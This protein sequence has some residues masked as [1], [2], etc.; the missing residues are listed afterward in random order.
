MQLGI[1]VVA[2][3]ARIPLPATSWDTGAALAIGMAASAGVLYVT[4]VATGRR[5]NRLIEA[6]TR[7]LQ[8]EAEEHRRTAAE[9][10]ALQRTSSF[11]LQQ[12]PI[13]ITSTDASGVITAV[14]P[15]AVA[16]FGAP[17]AEAMIGLNLPAVPQAVESGVSGVFRRVL[18]GRHSE[19]FET[20]HRSSWGREIELRI[21]VVQLLDGE[22]NL[23]G[24]IAMT[25]DVAERRMATLALADSEQRLAL[26][27]RHMP[28]M[29]FAFDEAYHLLAWNEECERVTGYT[30]AETLGRHDMFNLLFPDDAYRTALL[31]SMTSAQ[32][33]YRDAETEIRCRDGSTR[34]IAWSS[35]SLHAPVPGW[36]AWGVGIDVTARK[37]AEAQLL[38]AQK[39]ESV[40]RLAG[41]VAHDVNNLM[42]A[43]IGHAELAS[44][45]L[46]EIGSLRDDLAEICATAERAGEMAKQLLAFSR[47]QVVEPAEVL[48]D[49]LT[50]SM[51]VMLSRLIGEDVQLVMSAQP[52]LWHVRVDPSQMQQVVLN[53]VVNARDAMP[54]GGMI[55]VRTDNVS[56][57]GREFVRMTVSDTGAG[58]D[59][60]TQQRIFEPFFTTKGAG[61]GSGLGLSTCYGIVSQ[62]GG[63]LEVDS[64]PGQGTTFRIELPR[65]EAPAVE[66]E[67]PRGD[68]AAAAGDAT[69]LLVE[70][71][72]AVRS[73]A[74]RALAAQGYAVLEARNGVEALAVACRHAGHIDLV[75]SDV[76]MPEMGGVE[77]AARLHDS[78]PATRIMY[79]SG[80]T[81]DQTIPIPPSG[82]PVPVLTKPF[83]SAILVRRVREVLRSQAAP[84]TAA[85]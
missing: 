35:L 64:A 43:I 12:A 75:L 29:I 57:D 3:I 67:A 41:G 74:V 39:M 2:E 42:T 25:E 60:E 49:E 65:T 23:I 40:G 10:R 26:I 66:S 48:L 54:H 6:R 45:A 53:L 79:M 80:F 76:V 28:V 8:R 30:A 22:G 7:A 32:G 61:I 62:A 21:Q 19:T 36:A 20:T 85:G 1:T 83:T 69:I 56:E 27:V 55:T 11:L 59:A 18:A 84:L 9:L 14:N 17:G 31:Q 38:Q 15:A 34:T 78:R 71:Q 47:R 44:I 46:P 72:D 33:M 24:T 51:R 50:V 77:L 16:I 73:F 81:G 52:G 58:M 37:Q 4:I 70:D 5:F 13:G 82:H 68:D 63:S